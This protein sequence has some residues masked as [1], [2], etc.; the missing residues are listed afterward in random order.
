M[1]RVKEMRKRREEGKK[2]KGD[3]CE[4]KKGRSAVT[5]ETEKREEACAQ[6]LT[7]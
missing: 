2:G 1:P 7:F 3:A 6:K 4:E 5:K